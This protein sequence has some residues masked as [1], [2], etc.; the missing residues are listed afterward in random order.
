[1]ISEGENHFDDPNWDDV[2]LSNEEADTIEKEYSLGDRK[3]IVEDGKI[4]VKR[5]NK[6]ILKEQRSEKIKKAKNIDELKQIILEL[7]D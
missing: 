5:T 6:S 1:M 4:K 3:L 7:I 2:V